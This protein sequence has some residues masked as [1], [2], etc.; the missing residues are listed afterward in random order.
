MTQTIDTGTDELLCT[1]EDGVATLTL[2]RPDARNALSDTLSPAIREMVPALGDNKD[3]GVLILT[4]AGTAFCAGGDVKGM[5]G[6]SSKKDWTYEE[7]VDDLIMRQRKLTG[8]IYNLR[9]PTIAVLPG[10]AVGAGLSLA[11]ACDMRIAADSAFISTG[12]AR[13]G[14][15]GDYGMSWFLTQLVGPSKARE[16]FYTGERV[17][18]ATCEKLGL[19]NRVYPDDVVRDEAFTLARTIAAGPVLAMGYMKDNL[20]VATT[21]DLDGALVQEAKTMMKAAATNDHREA[22]EAFVEKRKPNFTGT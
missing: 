21:T 10:P 16:L 6:R 17:D 14:L 15:S 18:A 12:Y 4:G 20:D 5:G 13:V 22:V 11:L 8:A 9:K 19:V 7:R 1:I 3:V 2:N